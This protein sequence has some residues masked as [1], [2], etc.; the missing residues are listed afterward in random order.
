MEATPDELSTYRT[1]SGA[2]VPR[3]IAWTSSRDADGRDNLAPYSFFTIA[4]VDPPILAVCP[5]NF[6]PD[7]KDTPANAIET[8][9]F[10]INVV[11][12]PH[13]KVMNESSEAIS[14]GENEFDHVGVEAAECTVVDAPRVADAPVTFECRL[15]DAV[16]LPTSILLLGE[17]VN[18]HLDESVLVD[19]KLD[20]EKI[21]AIGRLAGGY[22]A[23]TRD[24]FHM[25]RPG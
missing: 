2:V 16:E 1:L 11:T 22:Y 23:Y 4:C 13:A 24:R 21:D 3:P 8:G 7:L 9:E 5:M 15:Y 12:A 10:A 20:V 14:S 6:E 19:G 25:E 17:V 18:V